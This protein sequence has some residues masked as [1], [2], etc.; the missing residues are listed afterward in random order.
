MTESHSPAAN[1]L[2]ALALAVADRLREAMEHSD[3]EL[4][5]SEPATLVTL[6]HYPGQSIVALGGTLGLTHSGTVGSQAG[7]SPRSP[8]IA[9]ARGNSAGCA[10]NRCARATPTAR[11]TTRPGDDA[12]LGSRFTEILR[13]HGTLRLLLPALVARLPDSI[14][15]TGI[16]V[17]VRSATGSYSVAGLTAGAFGSSTAVSAPLAGRAL[18]RLG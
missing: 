5:A 15:G 1:L 18:D 3:D 14:A 11:S 4:A 10:M 13:Q 9:P 7:C 2:G 8:P 16:V 6:A 12:V 17:L